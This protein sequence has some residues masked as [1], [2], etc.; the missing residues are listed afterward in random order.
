[1]KYVMLETD[2]GAK[3]PFIFPESLVHSDMADILRFALCRNNI[4]AAVVSAGFV[5]LEKCTTHGNSESLKG[6]APAPVDAIRMQFGDAI[7]F[8]PDEIVGVLA[9][10]LK[11]VRNDE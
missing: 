10:Q 1:M 3:L 9:K 4:F 5:E 2:N 7:A 6:L 8:M 11:E